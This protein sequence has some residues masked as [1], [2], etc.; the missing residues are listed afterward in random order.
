MTENMAEIEVQLGSG[1]LGREF[2]YGTSPLLPGSAEVAHL[3][4]ATLFEQG[5]VAATMLDVRKTLLREQAVQ[6]LTE[7]FEAHD[8]TV[9]SL[10]E[11]YEELRKARPA[12]LELVMDTV[13]ATGV[14]LDSEIR[15]KGLRSIAAKALLR[16]AK[17]DSAPIVDG[18]GARIAVVGAHP[19]YFVEHVRQRGELP[20]ELPGGVATVQTTGSIHSPMYQRGNVGYKLAI[21]IPGPAVVHG[22]LLAYDPRGL[23][24]YEAT[25]G[26]FEARRRRAL[27]LVIGT[28]AVRKLDEHYHRTVDQWK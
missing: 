28:Q 15:V 5:I 25:R 14:R 21:P 6:R 26:G 17:D 24:A 20:R 27:E 18:L 4:A 19:G 10:R 16:L 12:F 3:V 7:P 1:G 2:E 23:R 8:G 11:A 9:P 13:H 22:E